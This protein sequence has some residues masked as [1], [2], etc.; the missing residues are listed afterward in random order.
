MSYTERVPI[1]RRVADYEWRERI[2]VREREG[3]GFK[4]SEKGEVGLL[5]FPLG[6]GV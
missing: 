4:G 6:M 3:G 5:V 1:Y 2:T